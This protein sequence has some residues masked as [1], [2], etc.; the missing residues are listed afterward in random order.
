LGIRLLQRSASTCSRKL[1][2][3]EKRA[4][5]SNRWKGSARETDT[6]H[7]VFATSAHPRISIENVNGDITVDEWDKNTIGSA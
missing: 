2:L 3:Y 7:Q 6:I 4:G 5:V 1:R